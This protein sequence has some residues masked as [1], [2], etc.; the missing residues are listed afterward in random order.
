MRAPPSSV[1]CGTRVHHEYYGYL[2][3]G[4]IDLSSVLKELSVSELC[5]RNGRKFF[6]VNRKGKRGFAYFFDC[7][8]VRVPVIQRAGGGSVQFYCSATGIQRRN[9]NWLWDRNYGK[10]SCTGSMSGIKGYYDKKAGHVR[11]QL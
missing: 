11:F 1:V 6:S 9:E 10:D 7:L 5:G 4:F 2:L 8:G 3:R